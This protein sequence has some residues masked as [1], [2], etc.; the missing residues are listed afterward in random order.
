MALVGIGIS[1]DSLIH[2]W[3]TGNVRWDDMMGVM[4]LFENDQG[5]YNAP[6]WSGPSSCTC[7]VRIKGYSVDVVVSCVLRYVHLVWL[8]LMGVI[9]CPISD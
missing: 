1:W 3:Q 9:S 8:Y 7:S 4:T 6:W 5:G 2:C